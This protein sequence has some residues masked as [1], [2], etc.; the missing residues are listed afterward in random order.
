MPLPLEAYAVLVEI[1]YDGWRTSWIFKNAYPN[2]IREVQICNP[3]KFQPAA[4]E[5][6]EFWR[7]FENP[8]WGPP[9]SWISWEVDFG[10]AAT[11][12]M[13]YL[14]FIG[15]PFQGDA[16]IRCDRPKSMMAGG[17][18]LGIYILSFWTPHV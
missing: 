15:L 14:I 11:L 3:V 5:M 10:H 8:T 13:V 1:Q 18:H 12:R 9:P 16:S 4:M 7:I 2:V 17:G 6:A